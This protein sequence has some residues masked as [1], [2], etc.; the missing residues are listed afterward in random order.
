M[1]KKYF[2]KKYKLAYL[3]SIFSSH[4]LLK[5]F[6]SKSNIQD[7]ISLNLLSDD[8]Y[9]HINNV[10]EMGSLCKI[11]IENI[12]IEET[13]FKHFLQ[14]FKP[15]ILKND[16]FVYIKE[17]IYHSVN[18]SITR[19]FSNEYQ[20]KLLDKYFL[21][22]DTFDIEPTLLLHNNADDRTNMAKKMIIFLTNEK[23]DVRN[24][25]FYNLQRSL[26]ENNSN[27]Y[28][29]Y[30]KIINQHMTW[31]ELS[32]IYG[33]CYFDRYKKTNPLLCLNKIKSLINLTNDSDV[34]NLIN[35][36]KKSYLEKI[37]FDL[38]TENKQKNSKSKKI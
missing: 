19:Q 16:R 15:Y 5:N 7:D 6:N 33:D 37:Y 11:F 23:D 28:L 34:C 18:Y 27:Y 17:E 35:T 1:D 29:L 36:N 2:K 24:D 21:F 8:V 32:L 26:K 20:Q 22:L 12:L 13:V 4:H 31:I 30:E 38:L 14:K 25:L 10:E 3:L 9:F